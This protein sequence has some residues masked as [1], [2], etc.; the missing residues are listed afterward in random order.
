MQSSKHEKVK[1]KGEHPPTHTQKSPKPINFI[2]QASL[3]GCHAVS[4]Q[5]TQAEVKRI[6]ISCKA[7]QQDFCW[8][9]KITTPN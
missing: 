3:T 7:R 8:E 5:V 9:V 1:T 4:I 2:K 6:K